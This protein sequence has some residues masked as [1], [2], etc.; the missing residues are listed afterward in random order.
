M[1]KVIFDVDGVLLSEE[2]YYDVSGLTVWEILYSKDYMGLPTERDTFD[3]RHITDGQIAMIRSEVWNHDIL[4]SYLKS[5]GINSNWEMVHADLLTTLWLFCREYKRRTGGDIL[6]LALDTEKDCRKAGLLLMG[7]PIPQAEDVLALWQKVIPEEAKGPDFFAA[8]LS[9]MGDTF[10]VVPSWAPLGGPLWKIHL[11][12]FQAWY[13]GDDEFIRQNGKLPWGGGKKGFLREEL[14]LAP[15]PSVRSLFRRLKEAGY[16]IA[17]ATGRSRNEMTI[18]F[19]ELGWYDEFDP[20]FLATATDAEEAARRLH[21]GSLDKPH[22]FIYE[23]AMYGRCPEAY[24]SYVKG[25]S[26]PT[27]EDEVWVVGDSYSD[28]I[29][30]R[31]AGAKIIGVLT[32]LEGDRAAFMFEKAGAPYVKRVTDIEPVIFS[33]KK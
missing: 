5:H 24:E 18:P 10:G 23:C 13:L 15:A 21:T 22:P 26:V 9:A 2:R 11:A 32:G 4:L 25:D 29:G 20:L 19:K 12:A 14:P 1:K 3:P 16:A 30:A 33:G 8:L 17:V 31:A 6:Y 27:P 7:L 28:V